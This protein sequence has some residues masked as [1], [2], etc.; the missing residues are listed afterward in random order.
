MAE[1]SVELRR[2]A[3][4]GR[5]ILRDI[6]FECERGQ[7]LSVLGPNGVGKTTLLKTLVGLLPYDGRV[8]VSGKSLESIDARERARLLAYVPQ[9]SMLDA[10]MSVTNVVAQGRYCHQDVWGRVTPED[11]RAVDAALG[12]MSLD[13]LRERDFTELSSGEQRRVLLA[14][15]L[16]TQASVVV[17][18]EPTAALDLSHALVLFRHLRRL[19]DTGITVVT[20]LHDITEAERFSDCIGVLHEEQ[21]RFFGTPPLPDDLLRQVYG[22]E[23]STATSRSFELPDDGGAS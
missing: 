23:V 5:T 13:S 22:V 1:L 12:A 14:R 15:A 17:L 21:L 2:V 18:D 3:L 10:R 20:V 16:A 11:R 6:E 4:K 7:I 8:S 9:R 19:A